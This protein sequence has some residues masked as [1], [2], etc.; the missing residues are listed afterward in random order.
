MKKVKLTSLKV[1]S[2]VTSLDKKYQAQLKGGGY[3]NILC[4]TD[5]GPDSQNM[6]V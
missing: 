1:Q 2:F 3:G 6:C 4:P 5:G